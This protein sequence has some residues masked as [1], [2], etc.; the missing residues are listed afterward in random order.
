MRSVKICIDIGKIFIKAK[1]SSTK[2]LF[3]Q[4]ARY[5]GRVQIYVVGAVGV[6]VAVLTLVVGPQAW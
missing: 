5:S 3:Y 4:I 2:A 6:V 1:S